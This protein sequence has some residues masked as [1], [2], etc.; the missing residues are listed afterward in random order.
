MYLAV[1]K[2]SSTIV[3]YPKV[4]FHCLNGKS[5]NMNGFQ[6]AVTGKNIRINQQ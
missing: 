3:A 1:R 2:H 6:F 4:F 5:W